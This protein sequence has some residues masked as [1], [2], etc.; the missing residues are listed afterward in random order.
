M[1]ERKAASLTPQP[2][3]RPPGTLVMLGPRDG[4]LWLLNTMGQAMALDLSHPGLLALSLLACGDES[5]A[6]ETSHH[7]PSLI[8]MLT[9]SSYTHA[10]CVLFPIHQWLTVAV[11]HSRLDLDAQDDFALLALHLGKIPHL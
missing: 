7:H 3:L 10:D 6:G 1:K 5:G 11:A 8:L 9:V 2:A 4:S